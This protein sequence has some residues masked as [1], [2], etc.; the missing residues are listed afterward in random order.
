MTFILVVLYNT[1]LQ[2]TWGLIQIVSTA[3]VLHIQLFLKNHWKSIRKSSQST[4]RDIV[5]EI[6]LLQLN[7]SV[8][9][10]FSSINNSV[11]NIFIHRYQSTIRMWSSFFIEWV[12]KKTFIYWFSPLLFSLSVKK[13]A[14]PCSFEVILYHLHIRELTYSFV[15]I[16]YRSFNY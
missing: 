8:N 16:N 5:M 12:I 10:Y 4:P 3:Q 6:P 2:L 14:I 15:F 9:Y 11:Q 7:S 13:S 1:W